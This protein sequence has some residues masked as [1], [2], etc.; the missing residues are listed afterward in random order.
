MC[1]A[2]GCG[3]VRRADSASGRGIRHG[4]VDQIRSADAAAGVPFG[5]VAQMPGPVSGQASR[6]EWDLPKGPHRDGSLRGIFHAEPVVP[7]PSAAAGASAV[8]VAS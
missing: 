1:E 4:A 5:F 6:N 2:A 7:G 3:K 8:I